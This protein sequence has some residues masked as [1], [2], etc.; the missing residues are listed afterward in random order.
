MMTR[1]VQAPSKP[2][3]LRGTSG[4]SPA[5]YAGMVVC[6]GVA[7][8]PPT[9]ELGSRRRRASPWRRSWELIGTALWSRCPSVGRLL[10]PLQRS[11]GPVGQWLWEQMARPADVLTMR[12]AA[13]FSFALLMRLLASYRLRSCSGWRR[14]PADLT[15]MWG[16]TQSLSGPVTD[17]AVG[18]QAEPTRNRLL[19]GQ[20]ATLRGQP[21][22]VQGLGT[23]LTA[24]CWHPARRARGKSPSATP[25]R[26]LQPAVGDRFELICRPSDAS[27]EGIEADYLLDTEA[28]IPWSIFS[29][30]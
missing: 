15:S 7:F 29:V 23:S 17:T 22:I 13:G 16:R 9:R 6:R 12:A 28:K 18:D 20:E 19:G 3:P 8:H 5:R 14:F 30:R 27:S 25:E 24:A 4:H 10:R 1:R 2:R 21:D 11:W 26:A